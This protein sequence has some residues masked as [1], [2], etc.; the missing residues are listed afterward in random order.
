MM[1]FL[2][3]VDVCQCQK[4]TQDNCCNI[5]ATDKTRFLLF[6]L[7]F[8]FHRSPYA[9]NL[10]S[11]IKDLFIFPLIVF[12]KI[13]RERPLLTFVPPYHFYPVVSNGMLAE[14]KI[15]V[16]LQNTRLK[17]IKE[18][19]GKTLLLNHFLVKLPV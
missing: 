2:G 9:N 1:T 10:F 6:Y 16:V 15:I 11:N 8:C 4:K 5:V 12:F 7:Q 17:E 18:F 19:L 13:F 3:I 14:C